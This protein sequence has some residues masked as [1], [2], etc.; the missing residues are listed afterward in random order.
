MAKKKRMSSALKNALEDLLRERRLSAAGAAAARRGP[1][2]ASAVLRRRRL[3][4]GCSRAACRAARCP[5]S[6]VPASSGRTGLAL[7]LAARPTGA[8]ALV[9]WVD[10]GGSFRSRRRR[11]SRG[12]TCRGCCGCAAAGGSALPRALAAVGTCSDRASSRRSC[13]TSPACRPTSCAAL[14]GTTWIR[15]QRTIEDSP[16]ALLL[17]AARARRLRSG[18]RLAGARSRR[19]RNGRARRDRAALLGGLAG[20]A[21]AGRHAPRGAAFRLHAV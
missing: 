9:A 2:P 3:S 4:T 15:L 21:R 17:I 12:W 11:P 1:P 18:R 14:P 20:D 10:P 19:A 13:S 7:A 6:T 8:G 16:T 5:R